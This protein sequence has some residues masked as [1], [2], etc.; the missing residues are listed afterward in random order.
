MKTIRNLS[1]LVIAAAVLLVG[2]CSQTQPDV[3]TKLDTL[4]V[5]MAAANLHLMEIREQL[6]DANASLKKIA[7]R[8]RILPLGAEDQNE[9]SLLVPTAAADLPAAIK[10]GFNFI[11]HMGHSKEEIIQFVQSHFAAIYDRRIKVPTIG[12][13][14][15]KNQIQ[16]DIADDINKLSQ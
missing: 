10:D 7:A 8:P 5:D 4:D 16:Q 6:V 9:H 11:I 12:T 3:A 2:G 13:G 15:I 1:P 14:L